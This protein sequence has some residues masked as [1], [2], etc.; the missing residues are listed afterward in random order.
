MGTL[1]PTG[2]KRKAAS[3]AEAGAQ[4]VPGVDRRIEA[5]GR[6]VSLHDPRRAVIGQRHIGHPAAE[7]HDAEYRAAADLGCRQS[8]LHR[9]DLPGRLAW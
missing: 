2:H 3:A 9:L 5:H 6:G 1:W 4:R 8:G 7:R